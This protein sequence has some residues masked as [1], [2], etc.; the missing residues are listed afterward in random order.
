LEKLNYGNDCDNNL[1]AIKNVPTYV[2][3]TLDYEKSLK[4]K[5]LN[6]F[7]AKH[8]STHYKIAR[9]FLEQGKH[10]LVEKSLTRILEKHLN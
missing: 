10:L 3:N 4:M 6:T 5:I 1:E 9:L 8:A 7:L 2:K